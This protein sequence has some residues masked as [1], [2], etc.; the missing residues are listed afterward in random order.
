MFKDFKRFL[1][2]PSLLVT[3]ILSIAARSE[4]KEYAKL[5]DEIILSH[6]K[7]VLIQHLT[8]FSA[9]PYRLKSKSVK[10]NEVEK[11]LSNS[12]I[13]EI[14][15]KFDARFVGTIPLSLDHAKSDIDIICDAKN[16]EKAH[17]EIVDILKEIPHFVSIE[18]SYKPSRKYDTALIKGM[19]HVS[20]DQCIP[21]EIYIESKDVS[22]QNGYIHMVIEYLL[23]QIFPEKFSLIKLAKEQQSKTEIAFASIFDL[24]S[25]TDLD[26]SYDI[27]HKLYKDISSGIRNNCAATPGI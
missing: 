10:F 24:V 25:E 13:L 1:F 7:D 18:D 9:W 2:L 11:F 21:L 19:A 12:K 15:S 27:L 20:D 3:Q 4:T 26:N 5:C 22:E 23:L 8:A 16:V 17:T 6:S 14:L